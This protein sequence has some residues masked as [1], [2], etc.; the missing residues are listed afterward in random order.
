MRT[1][2]ERRYKKLLNSGFISPEARV[3]SKVPY[4]V[5]YMKDIINTRIG[6]KAKARARGVSYPQYERQIKELY[7]ASGYIKGNRRGHRLLDVWAMFREVEDRYKG[8]HP[9][10]QS[11]WLKK[12]TRFKDYVRK[13]KKS[14]IEGYYK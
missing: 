2:R 13:V 11:P 14:A 6:L 7:I 5:P 12:Q 8:E 10:Y 9:E 1:L 3:L 4:R